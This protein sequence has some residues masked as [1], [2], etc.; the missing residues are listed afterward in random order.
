VPREFTFLL[1]EI[2]ARGSPETAGTVASNGQRLG[3]EVS[4]GRSTGV[5]E[6]GAMEARANEETGRT[7]DPGRAELG[8]QT[9]PVRVLSRSVDA[10]RLSFGQRSS[11]QRKS[12]ASSFGSARNR[13]TRTRMSG[14]VG[15]GGE[16]PPAT[17]LSESDIPPF[18]SILG[19]TG[20]CSAATFRGLK[21]PLQRPSIA[22]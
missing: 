7:H 9:R 3:A 15:A 11:W 4:R 18:S 2:C 21:V 6:P 8:R 16:I 14:G 10:D 17:R 5:H 19:L 13:R 20:R 22:S 1:R 12:A